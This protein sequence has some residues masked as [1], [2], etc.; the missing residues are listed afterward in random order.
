M[1]LVLVDALVTSHL[2]TT[3]CRDGDVRYVDSD[4]EEPKIEICKDDVSIKLESNFQVESEDSPVRDLIVS[5]ISADSIVL[6]WRAVDPSILKYDISC[7]SSYTT[8]TTYMVKG[9]ESAILTYLPPSSDYQCCVKAYLNKNL[10]KFA[11]YIS[12][13][14][15]DVNLQG[16]SVTEPY[17]LIYFLAGLV[18]FLLVTVGVLA[19]GCFCVVVSKKKSQ[20]TH[21]RYVC[22]TVTYTGKKNS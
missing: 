13:S 15:V 16:E 6:N 18:G 7:S 20:N 8:I 9:A 22:I 14:C 5:S 21:P 17:L 1:F 2:L 4:L 10:T 12:T 3:V 19:V 11:T